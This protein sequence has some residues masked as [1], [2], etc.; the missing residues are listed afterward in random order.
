MRLFKVV[1]GGQP[2]VAKDTSGLPSL[3]VVSGITRG[4]C[5]ESDDE[6]ALWVVQGSTRLCCTCK[7][8]ANDIRQPGAAA[9]QA[10]FYVQI[11]S[12]TAHVDST[13][14]EK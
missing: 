8:P 13:D 6:S 7:Q 12:H 9:L 3:M 1:R 11:Q 14:S 4:H 2:D 5:A 10:R